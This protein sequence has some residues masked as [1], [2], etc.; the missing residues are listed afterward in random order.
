MNSKEIVNRVFLFNA[1]V[2]KMDGDKKGGLNKSF[3]FNRME[4][5]GS[6]GDLGTILPLA[7]AMILMNGMDPVAVF[8]CFGM[9][10]IFSGVY[11]GVTMPVEPMKIIAAYAIA[12]DITAAQIQ[13]SSLLL[14]I[15]LLVIGG[16]SLISFI[17][18]AIPLSV[19]R[20]VQLSTGTLLVIKG[21]QLMTGTSPFQ[22]MYNLAEPFLS[23]QKLGPIPIGILIGSVLSLITLFLLD[24]KRV[25]AAVTVFG[26]GLLIGILFHQPDSSANI[27]KL[28]FNMPTLMPYG[29][30]SLN[31]FSFALLILVLPQ[32]PMTIGNAVI[33]NADLTAQYFPETG[34][35]VTGKTLC[36]SMGAANVLCYF[37][38]GIPMCHGAGGLASRYRFG[39]RT[40][41]SNII[42]GCL[43]LGL[44]ILFGQNI[45]GL[46]HY[47]PMACLG[48]LLVFAGIQLS[49]TLL[50]VQTRKDLFVVLIMVGITLA[51]NLAAGFILGIIAAYLLRSEKINI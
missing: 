16:T 43:F 37:L 24:N 17:S 47:I 23:I 8:I 14:G 48:V 46:L 15:I 39:A 36:L 41:G 1:I 18:R 31:D 50:T 20:G 30:P 42:I 6:L 21:I 38:G 9:Y 4:L 49:L 27:F 26:I 44:V 33:A 51:H 13:S 5:S 11:F 32:I 7:L 22:Q 12:S 25:P 28:S 29:T 10:Y 2:M 19:I 35:K 45:L 34:K 40:A 3:A